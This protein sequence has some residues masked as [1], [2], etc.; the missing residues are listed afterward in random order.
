MAQITKKKNTA[1]FT[2]QL[3]NTE[4]INKFNEIKATTIDPKSKKPITVPALFEA[5][6]EHY[7]LPKNVSEKKIETLLEEKIDLEN[8]LSEEKEKHEILIKEL[9]QEKID[10]ETE[11]T[12]LKDAGNNNTGLNPKLDTF[13]DG[14]VITDNDVIDLLIQDNTELKNT[15]IALAAKKY[16]L[17]GKQFVCEFAEEVSLLAKKCRKAIETDGY[18]KDV[19]DGNFPNKLANLCVKNFLLQN[20]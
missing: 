19:N 16:E 18:L 3:V 5:M 10:L 14:N 4:I 9:L 13:R 17:T 7:T 6:V 20:Y 12:E 15:N 2:A 11:I 8:K 1:Q